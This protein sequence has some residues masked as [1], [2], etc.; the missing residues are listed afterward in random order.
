MRKMLNEKTMVFTDLVIVIDN[1]SYYLGVVFEPVV[2]FANRSYTKSIRE[3]RLYRFERGRF[4][5]VM[6][7][8]AVLIQRW[9]GMLGELAA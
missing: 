2:D 3:Y 1:E 6:Q 4:R 9:S 5:Y 7:V 8:P